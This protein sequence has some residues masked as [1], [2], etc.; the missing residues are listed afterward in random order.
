MKTATKRPPIQ[1][2]KSMRVLRVKPGDVVVLTTKDHVNDETASRLVT[3]MQRVIPPDTKV[4]V[5][6]PGISLGVMRP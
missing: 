4:I 6:A 2:I 5:L 3:M 1:I